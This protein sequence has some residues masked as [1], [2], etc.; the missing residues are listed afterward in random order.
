MLSPDRVAD[1]PQKRRILPQMCIGGK[2]SAAD[3]NGI[4]VLCPIF[5][6]GINKAISY[7]SDFLRGTKF[8]KIKSANTVRKITVD[9]AYMEGRIPR[10]TS[11]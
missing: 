10:R 4:G 5:T 1:D 11:L 3:F 6:G 8:V 7:F 2:G 9:R